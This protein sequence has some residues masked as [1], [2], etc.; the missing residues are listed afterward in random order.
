[1]PTRGSAVRPGGGWS[2][3]CWPCADR[4]STTRPYGAG[5]AVGSRGSS[6]RCS[7][8]W[9]SRGYLRT[10][11]LQSG[12]AAPGC[13]P[14]DQRRDPFTPWHRKQDGLGLAVRHLACSARQP[15]D[16]LPATPHFSSNVNSYGSRPCVCP[17]RSH[18]GGQVHSSVACLHMP[19]THQGYLRPPDRPAAAHPVEAPALVGSFGIGPDTAAILLIAPGSNP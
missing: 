6:R 3:N 19:S 15:A 11:M 5:C 14:Q 16:R 2:A 8:S 12:P 4:T 9:P 18:I 10:T 13:Q 1:M 17:V 7:C